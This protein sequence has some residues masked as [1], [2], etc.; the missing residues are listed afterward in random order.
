MRIAFAF[1]GSLPSPQA[2]AE[3]FLQTAAA[4]RRRGHEVSVLFPSPS[5]PSSA[6]DEVVG[7][8]DLD[9]AL[10]LVPV[11]NP[12]GQKT[13]QHAWQAAR[14][15]WTRESR[16][17]DVLY[18]RNVAIL[19][20]AMQGK[21]PVFFDHYRPLPDQVPFIQPL[22]R[23]WMSDPRFLGMA[24]HS[25]IARKSFL[26]IGIPSERLRVVYNGFDP[27][28]MVP[29]LSK[30]RARASLGWSP[31]RT[32]VVYTGRISETKGLD[33]VFAMADRLPSVDFV[34]V[35]SSGDGNRVERQAESKRN[36]RLVAWQSPRETIPYLYAADVLLI[37]PSAS[38]LEEFGRTVLPLKVFLYLAAGRPILAGDTPDLREVLEHEENAL[39][40]EPEDVS[41]AAR[42]VRRLCEDADLAARLAAN[43]KAAAKKLT[44]DARAKRLD[45]FL[46]DRLSA[47]R[48]RD[49][50][51]GWSLGGWLRECIGR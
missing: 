51:L 42:A 40:V 41:Q 49:V 8:F 45:E 7:Y 15:P 39:L 32:T 47:P 22:L 36:V 31:D 21:T 43:A 46:T 30:E 29:E 33:V 48:V 27:A 16:E 34:L 11:P 9:R 6:I 26:R 38:P 20:G 2:D 10:R 23:R 50:E 37:P 4:L 3:V 17:S 12:F 18:T 28:R 25:N 1:E 24:C 35:G 14:V 19:G 5:T 44:W 13:L